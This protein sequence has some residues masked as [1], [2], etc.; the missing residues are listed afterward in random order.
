MYIMYVEHPHQNTP[1]TEA[2]L[3]SHISLIS[4]STYPVFLL[5]ILVIGLRKGH[6]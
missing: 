1:T 3:V 5:S 4:W 2:Q 6:D